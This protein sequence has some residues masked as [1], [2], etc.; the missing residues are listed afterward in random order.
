MESDTYLGEYLQSDPKGAQNKMYFPQ[1][2]CKRK[3][4]FWESKYDLLND[5]AKND[6]TGGM[7]WHG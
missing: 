2:F 4:G 7:N 6:G 3:E 5:L 1:K